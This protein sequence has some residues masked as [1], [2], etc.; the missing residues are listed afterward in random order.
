[1]NTNQGGSASNGLVWM[2]ILAFSSTSSLAFFRHDSA[3]GPYFAIFV[4]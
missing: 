4:N 2:T 3:V 1:M